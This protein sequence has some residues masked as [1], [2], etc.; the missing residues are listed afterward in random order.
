MYLLYTLTSTT[1]RYDCENCTKVPTSF[2]EKIRYTV[3][4][5]E[6][7]KSTTVFSP[8]EQEKNDKQEQTED[9]ILDIVSR[10]EKSVVDAIIKTHE[11]NQDEIINLLHSELKGEKNMKD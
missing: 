2:K 10:V 5:P 3:K 4:D 11:K 9:K 8:K 6:S 1:R 7:K